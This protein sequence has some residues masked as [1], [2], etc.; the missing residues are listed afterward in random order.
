MKLITQ[1]KKARH[2]YH[3]LDTYEAGIKLK[4]SEIK[5]IRAGKINISDSYVTFKGNEA[6]LLNTHISK[7][8]KS[9]IFNHSETRQR[10]LLLNKSEIRKLV[11]Q[12]QLQGHSVIP[13][14]VYLKEGLCKVEI[15]L[16]KGKKLYDKREDLKQRDQQERLSKQLKG[17]Y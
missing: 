3:I 12:V 8:D 1:N 16:V 13:L 2:D 15:A 10:K 11:S 4:G 9:N 7:F 14:R 17:R 6:F 5:S